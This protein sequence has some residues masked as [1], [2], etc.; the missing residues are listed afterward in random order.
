MSYARSPLLVCSI[1]MGTSMVAAPLWSGL[2]GT[3]K[4]PQ[5]LRLLKYWPGWVDGKQPALCGS[6][7][8]KFEGFLVTNS[9]ANSIGGTLLRQT[10]ADHFCRLLRLPGNPLDLPVHLLI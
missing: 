2:S 9:V 5:T 1:T 7:V 4:H 3:D 8:Q 6:A 10:L